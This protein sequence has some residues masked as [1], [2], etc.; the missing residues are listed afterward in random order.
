MSSLRQPAAG[1]QWGASPTTR[2]ARPTSTAR[3]YQIGRRICHNCIHASRCSLSS[4]SPLPIFHCEE[5]ECADSASAEVGHGDGGVTA[6]L[7]WSARSV[8]ARSQAYTGL[9]SDCAHRSDCMFANAEG[10]V[11]HC[12]EYE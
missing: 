1:L 7:S 12:E 11:W 3:I 4:G 6:V 5:F 8:P 10:G 9:C 2:K